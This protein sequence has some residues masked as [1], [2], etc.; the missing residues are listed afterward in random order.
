MIKELMEEITAFQGTIEVHP[1]GDM[2]DVTPPIGERL[3]RLEEKMDALICAVEEL[4]SG[5]DEMRKE[6]NDA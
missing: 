4:K 1:T 5:I 6:I 2:W 3:I